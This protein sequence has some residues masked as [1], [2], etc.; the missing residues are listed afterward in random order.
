VIRRLVPGDKVAVAQ[1]CGRVSSDDFVPLYF[2][3]II[4][5]K[6]GFGLEENGVLVGIVFSSVTLDG[7]AWLF[8]LRVDPG[9]QRKGIGRC[10]TEQALKEIPRS[11]RLVRLGIF[12]DNRASMQLAR[13][14]GFSERA[15]YFFREFRG[16][17]PRVS[18]VKLEHV[19]PERLEEILARLTSDRRLQANNL[20]LPHFYEWF[21]IA[22]GSLS[23]LIE[24]GWVWSAGGQLAVVS[25]E[26]VDSEVEIGYLS[27]PCNQVL[28]A[29]LDRFSTDVIEASLPSGPALENTLQQ[30]GFVV[31]SWGSRMTIYERLLPSDY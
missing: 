8:G 23:T 1:L 12:T 13:S 17:A 19:G 29:I 3:S 7:E 28:P 25:T 15:Q 4:N 16:A 14:F 5:Q 31:P 2:D 20:L 22:R 18:A 27:E 6:V 24:N 9:H 10:L 26:Q 11:C 30:F 21:R